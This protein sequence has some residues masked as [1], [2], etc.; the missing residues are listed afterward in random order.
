[1]QQRFAG[2]PPGIVEK[3]REVER[4]VPVE[5]HIQ[6]GRAR[7]AIISLVFILCLF[8]VSTAEF[9]SLMYAKE[10]Q[11]CSKEGRRT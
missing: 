9:A 6:V 2:V 4:L 8:F 3:A 10:R 1:M 5:G 7:A 11:D